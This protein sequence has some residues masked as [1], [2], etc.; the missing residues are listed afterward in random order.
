[1]MARNG[2]TP[3]TPWVTRVDRVWLLGS[4][5]KQFQKRQRETALMEQLSECVERLYEN[6]RQPG[7]NLETLASTAKAPVLSA[8]INQGQRLILTPLAKNEVGLLY[9]DNHDEAYEWVRRQ[10]SRLGTMLSKQQEF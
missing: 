7:L 8:R 4:Y 9:F 2:L 3:E 1:M 5:Q 10:G 6:P